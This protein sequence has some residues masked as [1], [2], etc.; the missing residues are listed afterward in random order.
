LKPS[1]GGLSGIIGMLSAIDRNQCPRSIGTPVRNPRN[2]HHLHHRDETREHG[3]RPPEDLTFYNR[4]AAA[5]R[6]ADRI[7][8]LSHGTGQSNASNVL[9]EWLV[10]HYP[11][12]YAKIIRQAEVNTSAMTEAQI[13]AYGRQALVSD[14][15]RQL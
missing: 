10:K 8:L 15:P 4:I 9:I 3:Q 7:V 5:L 2:P 13:L 11:S 14:A 1:T 12:V 6:G